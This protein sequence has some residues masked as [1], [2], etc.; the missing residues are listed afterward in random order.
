KKEQPTKKECNSEEKAS[1]ANVS[2][3]P[4]V[5]LKTLIVKIDVAGKMKRVRVVIDDGSQR[6]YILKHVVEELCLRPIGSEPIVHALFG[7]VK[8]D[9]IK[10]KRYKVSLTSLDDSFS[11]NVTM[12]DQATICSSIP[13]VP[14]GPWLGELKQRK[15]WLTD[16][17]DGAPD[18]EILLGADMVGRL[19]TGRMRHL[20]GGLLAV[21][22]KLG[23]TLMGEVP[24]IGGTESKALMISNLLNSDTC[25]S[26]MWKLETLGIT[27]PSETTSRLDLEKAAM[28]HFRS[29]VTVNEEGRYEVKLPWLAGHPAL[30]SNRAVAERRLVAA[31]SKLRAGGNL[32]AYHQVIEDWLEMGIIERVPGSELKSFGHYLP[33]RA[34]VKE[35][36]S[37]TKIRPVFD[38]SAHEKNSP[39]LND[40]LEKGPNLIETIPTVLLRF[41]EKRIGVVSDIAKAFLQLSLAS[42][43]RDFLRFLWWEEPN[44]E[45]VVELRHCRVVFGVSSSPFLLSAVI[46]YHLDHSPEKFRPVAELLRKAFY[47]DNVATSVGSE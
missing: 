27:D 31:T 21:E 19:L 3:S 41:R 25:L 16:V 32:R 7:G 35:N 8:T 1:L 20:K 10:H 44:M 46:E 38:A 37:T 14:R 2:N 15:I 40:C 45:H 11:C 28:D 29:T 9:P 26:S 24:R 4:E 12:L 6:S 13:R 47:V 36:S 34:V 5:L 18:V 17:G 30:S 23:W 43:E 22:T 39:S 33:H 42:N